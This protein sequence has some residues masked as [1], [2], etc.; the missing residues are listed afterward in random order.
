M[1]SSSIKS[2][3]ATQQQNAS[4]EI[5]KKHVG[6]DV[7]VKSS[8][9]VSLIEKCLCGVR[10]RPKKSHV[11]LGRTD[12]TFL[13][14]VKTE[15]ILGGDELKERNTDIEDAWNIYRRNKTTKLDNPNDMLSVLGKTFCRKLTRVRGERQKM[16]YFGLRLKSRD[17]QSST[18]SERKTKGT[19][20][21]GKAK[22][23]QEKTKVTKTKTKKAKQKEKENVS[24]VGKSAR[25]DNS[26]KPAIYL[27]CLHKM[28]GSGK[29]KQVQLAM[30]HKK[31]F[32]TVKW[33]PFVENDLQHMNPKPNTKMQYVGDLKFVQTPNV[34]ET[35][36]L[37]KYNC[38]WGHTFDKE[39][40]INIE[41]KA[42]IDWLLGKL[43]WNDKC[44]LIKG[45]CDEFRPTVDMP[46]SV[47]KKPHKVYMAC[48][49]KSKAKT[50]SK[51]K[52]TQVEKHTSGETKSEIKQDA[53]PRVAI[54]ID[55][56]AIDDDDELVIL[57]S[58]SSKI[59]LTTSLSLSNEDAPEPELK[60]RVGHKRKRISDDGNNETSNTPI[61]IAAGSRPS[62]EKG[63]AI[64]TLL[65]NKDTEKVKENPKVEK[66]P[67]EPAI[68][69]A[70]IGERVDWTAISTL[71]ADD[72][73]KCADITDTVY[74]SIRT[75]CNDFKV[76]GY[77][78][79]FR[80]MHMEIQV[81][82]RVALTFDPKIHM[83]L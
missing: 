82:E 30:N 46:E 41:Y 75:A 9:I 14:F 27:W 7:P 69:K 54:A 37:I 21:D 23:H 25:R 57:G 70:K 40:Q 59:D 34:D 15:F 80:D 43:K 29:D 1:S 78:V 63:S 3:S 32:F 24:S 58:P 28:R 10:H 83:S 36:G 12:V 52:R 16:H 77:S 56:S 66:Q 68:K 55:K 39:D 17:N 5:D 8:D 6:S 20:G 33:M 4:D 42:F 62:I 44:E 81:N 31:G 65:E 74:K 53:K 2:T 48:K 47:A 18:S 19:D 11:P 76:H 22:K 61:E 50:A 79:S 45:E 71:R 51:T 60:S 38:D 64:G 67:I 73:Q 13:Q 26:D 72:R 35:T 49:S